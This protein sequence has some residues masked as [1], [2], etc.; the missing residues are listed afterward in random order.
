MN[1]FSLVDYMNRY[2]LKHSLFLVLTPFRILEFLFAF[3]LFH[4]LFMLTLG[5]AYLTKVF[6]KVVRN[7]YD[8]QDRHLLVLQHGFDSNTLFENNPSFRF[9]YSLGALYN[10]T[11]VINPFGKKIWRTELS[12]FGS[13][14][15][16]GIE[17]LATFFSKLKRVL[18]PFYNSVIVL[19]FFRILIWLIIRYRGTNLTILSMTHNWVGALAVCL[20][21]SLLRARS[22]VEIRGNYELLNEL[23]GETVF[24]HINR[25]VKPIS[26]AVFKIEKIY[27]KI[28]LRRANLVICRNRNIVGHVRSIG[29]SA[30]NLVVNRTELHPVQETALT[31]KLVPTPELIP[32]DAIFVAR[33]SH[34][35]YPLDVVIAWKQL[36]EFRPRSRLL[37]VG[38]GPLLAN[39]KAFVLENGLLTNVDFYGAATHLEAI[40]LLANAKVGIETYGGSTLLEKGIAGCAVV[41][42]DIEWH[43][44]LLDHGSNGFLVSFRDTTE[45][46]NRILELL[47]NERLRLQF[48]SSLFKKCQ[49][50]YNRQEWWTKEMKLHLELRE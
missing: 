37:M 49:S 7:D 46:M 15:L 17:T 8:F 25:H 43:S 12:F 36:V 45:L 11:D 18:F 4:V 16:I 48:R 14:R 9:F 42:Y 39:L 28:L 21:S 6:T 33:F 29:G 32:Y 30:V 38:D 31:S 19:D 50:E 22:I 44:E 47:D 27:L 10:K 26:V 1:L 41:A 2:N 20:S 24:W 5:F 23:H 34:E 3:M 40:N 13:S 35:K